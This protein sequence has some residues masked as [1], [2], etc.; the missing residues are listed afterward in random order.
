M[1]YELKFKDESGKEIIVKC[2][3]IDWLVNDLL[4]CVNRGYTILYIKNLG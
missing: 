4:M 1:S 3:D 2:N